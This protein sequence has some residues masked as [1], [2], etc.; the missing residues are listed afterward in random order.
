MS[1]GGIALAVIAAIIAALMVFY[2]AVRWFV[3]ISLAIGLV[4]TL[5]LRVYYKHKPVKMQEHDKIFKL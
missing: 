3:L 1:K 2:P 5:L 4:V